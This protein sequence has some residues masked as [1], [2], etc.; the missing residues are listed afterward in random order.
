[1]QG[2]GRGEHPGAR[3]G[4]AVTTRPA[5]RARN[6]RPSRPLGRGQPA[7]GP[8]QPQSAP[9]G[10]RAALGAARHRRSLSRAR[11]AAPP[12]F[13]PVP[14]PPSPQPQAPNPGPAPTHCRRRPRRYTPAAKSKSARTSE[15]A[16]G[17]G[18]GGG[19][20][21][22][23]APGVA[24]PAARRGRRLPAEP[25]RHESGRPLPAARA[26]GQGPQRGASTGSAGPQAPPR[27][28]PQV[29]GPAHS[30][31]RR[32]AS[33]CNWISPALPQPS[34]RAPSDLGCP[35]LFRCLLTNMHGVPTTSQA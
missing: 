28:R 10:S 14:G 35:P 29:R 3:P 19:G 31:P 9:P 12:G 16:P 24:A 18:G 32:P 4:N 13:L 7:A 11:P 27:P 30:P 34:P 20:T 21:T 26:G 5:G 33:A 22:E 25:R 23:P 17:S 15:P 1:M 8:C 6:P 2:P